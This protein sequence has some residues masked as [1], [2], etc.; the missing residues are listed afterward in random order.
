M[1]LMAYMLTLLL[2]AWQLSSFAAGEAPESLE[3]RVGRGE[4]RAFIEAADLGRK[5]LIPAIEKFAADETWARTTLAKLGMRK[6]LDEIIGELITPTNSAAFRNRVCPNPLRDIRPEI[7]AH[8]TRLEALKKIAYMRDPSTVKIVA[9]L[10]YSA[11]P[12]PEPDCDVT[13]AP[14]RYEAALTLS[15][16]NQTRKLTN[17]PQAKFPVVNLADWQQWWEQNKDKYP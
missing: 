3:Q 12:A 6:Y 15:V 17:A 7:E 10:L 9:A 11:E 4:A 2:A 1:K 16:M 14:I 8:L 5:D 13:Y